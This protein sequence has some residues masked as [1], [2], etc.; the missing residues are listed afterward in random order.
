MSSSDTYLTPKKFAK[1]RVH[2][3]TVIAK[4]KTYKL[5]SHKISTSLLK[6]E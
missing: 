2:V 6:Q 5:L 3:E 4:V 1:H